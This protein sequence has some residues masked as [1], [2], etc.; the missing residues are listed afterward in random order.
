MM[1]ILMLMMMVNLMM[2][3]DDYGDNADD[4][5][6]DEYDGD[7]I[8]TPEAEP[9]EMEVAAQA[10]D[11]APATPPAAGCHGNKFESLGWPSDE[12]MSTSYVQ[13]V[14]TG[15]S[16]TWPGYPADLSVICMWQF[17]VC[18]GRSICSTDPCVIKRTPNAPHV[19]QK[20]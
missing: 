2:I 13:R 14:M 20:R 7:T 9:P 6:D 8:H 17:L 18:L 19:R 1:K 11:A 10:E 12:D 4:Y 15:Q 5:D 3:E 16:C